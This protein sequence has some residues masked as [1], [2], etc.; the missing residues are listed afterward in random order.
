MPGF[1]IPNSTAAG[2]EG[3]K[4]EGPKA[5]L[6]TSRDHRWVISICDRLEK[7]LLHAKKCN[8]PTVEIDTVTYHYGINEIYKP[9]K[10]RIRPVEFTFYS[11]HNTSTDMAAKYCFEWWSKHTIDVA[12]NSV[13]REWA[14]SPGIKVVLEMLDGK[15]KTVRKIKMFNCW[16]EF[17]SASDPDYTISE[18]STV[19][20][21]LRCDGF[22]EEDGDSSEDPYGN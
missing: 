6:E 8:R 21:R 7:I 4:Q 15:N 16:P 12:N 11:V 2:C 20:V 22:E 18:I 3:K 5:D 1:N 13:A 14:G 19:T 9:G 17:V 10:F